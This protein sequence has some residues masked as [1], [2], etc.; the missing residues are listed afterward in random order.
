MAIMIIVLGT[1]ITGFLFI[2]QNKE[3]IDKDQETVEKNRIIS[4]AISD[5]LM[6]HGRLPCPAPINAPRDSQYFG[7]ED[8]RNR[9][10]TQANYYNGLAAP[11]NFITTRGIV[12]VNPLPPGTGANQRP[13]AAPGNIKIGTLPVRNLNISDDYMIDGYG[14]RYVYAVT[15]RLAGYDTATGLANSNPNI[16][17]GAIDLVDSSGNS[18]P[19]QRAHVK[20]IFFSP[21]ADKR[22]AYDIEGALIQGCNMTAAPGEN[23][24]WQN[25][26]IP[27]AN[28]YSR[29][30]SS[31]FKTY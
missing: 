3:V 17:L 8:P 9:S 4:L 30:V 23:C 21:G 31:F 7:R 15:E 26:T 13:G 16:D 5:Y 28:H 10:C 11:N 1:M 12:S 29:F 14:H 19:S 25:A 2:Y 24:D 27:A 20:Y 22:G 6:R 18:L